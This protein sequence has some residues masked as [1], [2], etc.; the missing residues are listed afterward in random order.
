[1]KK[2]TSLVLIATLMSVAQGKVRNLDS[3]SQV[4]E[5]TKNDSIRLELLNI[6]CAEYNETNPSK[7]PIY[8]EEGYKL[9]QKFNKEYLQIVF[10]YQWGLSYYFGSKFKEAFEMMMKAQRHAEKAGNDTLSL[11]ALNV[12]AVIQA[13]MNRYDDALFYFRKIKSLAS[14]NNFSDTYLL[15]LNNIGN[16]HNHINNLDSAVFYYEKAYLTAKEKKRFDAQIYLANNLCEI[17]I[18][19]KKFD[20]ALQYATIATELSEEHRSVEYILISYNHLSSVYSKT[21]QYEKAEFYAQK[22]AQLADSLDMPEQKKFA[23]INLRDIYEL[24][25]NFRTALDY[26]KQISVINDTLFNRE[27]AKQILEMKTRYETEKH[28]QQIEKQ[29]IEIKQQQTQRNAILLGL[30]LSVILTVVIYIS[31]RRKVRYNK[32]ITLQNAEIINQK[33]EITAIAEGLTESNA[34]KDKFFSIIAHDLRNPFNHILGFTN[35]LQSNFDQYNSEEIKR[36]IDML[37]RSANTTYGLLENLLLWAN[38][39]RGKINF[40]PSNINLFDIVATESENLKD[41]AHS[42]QISVINK[43]PVDFQLFADENMLKTIIRNLISNA[44]KFTPK[45]G[46]VVINAAKVPEGNK[47]TVSDTGIGMSAE[48]V[49]KLFKIQEHITTKGTENEKG[50]GLGLI[51]CQEFVNQHKGKIYAESTPGKG[52]DFIIVLP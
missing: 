39:Q 27:N 11:A 5:K 31:Y 42:K 14:K 28:Q 26:Q 41:I 25:G 45:T 8:A 12:M 36:M 4:L 52:S 10:L 38:S 47:I 13:Q 1:M 17:Y 48:I 2:F 50:S 16:C 46:S 3:L 22:M 6:M 33:E 29:Q 32:L 24:S 44:L 9:S 43:V 34:T 20:R 19:K 7:V 21:G 35:L 15:A 49:A 30:S 23:L 40:S 18:K 37:N 51:L